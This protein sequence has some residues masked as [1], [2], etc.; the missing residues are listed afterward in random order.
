MSPPGTF[1]LQTGSRVHF[2]LFG[3][4]TDRG[5]SYGGLGAMASE[6]GLKLRIAPAD[7]MEFEGDQAER[8]REFTRKWLA[9]TGHRPPSP[10][11]IVL[12]QSPDSHVGLGTGTQIGLAVSA[13]LYRFYFGE[14][15]AVETLARSTGRGQRSAVGTYGFQRGGFIVDSGKA[16]GE[17]LSRLDFHCDLPVNWRFVFIQTSHPG[18]LSGGAEN[19]VFQQAKNR[20]VDHQQELVALTRETILPALLQ[21][22]FESFSEAIFRFGKTSGSYFAHVQG[23]PFNGPRITELVGQLRQSGIRGVGQTSWGPTVYALARS[24][25]EAEQIADLL[26]G[27][28]EPDET[29]TI[30][31]PRNHGYRLASVHASSTGAR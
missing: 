21:E 15:P 7:R 29:L 1:R 4:F 20:L 16:T 5:R 26:A 24:A 27:Q 28:L 31:A 30:A 10:C 12:E 13:L 2:G 8:L 9:A 23:G 22:D 17:E 25:D 14:V 18:G 6:P 19:R 3:G 11:R